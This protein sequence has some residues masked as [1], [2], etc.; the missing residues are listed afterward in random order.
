MVMEFTEDDVI[1]LDMTFAEII[2]EGLK[3]YR[4]RDKDNYPG[5]LA[6]MYP[7]ESEEELMG[8]WNTI[9]NQ[10]IW[11]FTQIK[12]WER[13]SP[14]NQYKFEMNSKSDNGLRIRMADIPAEVMAK[15]EEYSNKIQEGL[16]LF[17]KYFRCLND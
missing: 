4:L 6:N 8:R 17:T 9:I 16:N 10:M 5:A 15:H 11:A 12:D 1:N 3:A 7:G 13:E 14:I 2:V